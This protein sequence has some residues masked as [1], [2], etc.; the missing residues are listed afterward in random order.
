MAPDAAEVTCPPLKTHLNCRPSRVTLSLP[1]SHWAS[2]LLKWLLKCL[3]WE[4]TKN[5]LMEADLF[6]SCSGSPVT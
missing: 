5:P 2:S 1:L 4:V 3:A 6:S